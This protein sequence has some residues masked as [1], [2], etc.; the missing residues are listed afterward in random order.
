MRF[1]SNPP[2][3]RPPGTLSGATAYPGYELNDATM[4]ISTLTPRPRARPTELG[5]HG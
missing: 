3:R 1:R 5:F 2:L 4:T